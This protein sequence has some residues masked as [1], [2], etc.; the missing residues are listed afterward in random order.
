MTECP[1]P[2][3]QFAQLTSLAALPPLHDVKNPLG[4]VERTLSEYCARKNWFVPLHDRE[5]LVAEL[6]ATAWRLSRSDLPQGW[7]P[8]KGYPSFSSYLRWKLLFA[9]VQF[10]RSHYG[11]ARYGKALSKVWR[12]TDPDPEALSLQDVV[13]AIDENKLTPLQRQGFRHVV[14][15]WV[16]EGKT[17]SQL[18]AELGQSKRKL[19]DIKKDVLVGMAEQLEL[20]EVFLSPEELEALKV[21]EAEQL[22]E[23]A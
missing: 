17:F 2:S 1:Q 6:V 10:K 4:F 3:P 23:A 14:L 7:Q 8:S 18:E 15:P 5:D 13:H 11:D 12:S 19:S 21:D 20:R 16:I 22:E 9:I